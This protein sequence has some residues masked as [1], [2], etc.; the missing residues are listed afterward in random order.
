MSEQTLRDVFGGAGWD[1]AS[2]E[3]AT[4]RG[5]LDGA[6]VEMASGTSARSGASHLYLSC[7]VAPLIILVSPGKPDP[8][9]ARWNGD[10]NHARR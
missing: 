2:L 4:V 1:I 10:R 9:G 3:P 6:Q 7:R 5:E 8:P